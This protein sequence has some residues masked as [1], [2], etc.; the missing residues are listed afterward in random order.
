MNRWIQ[1]FRYELRQQFR[2]KAY[3]FITFGLPLIALAAFYGYQAYQDATESKGDEKPVDAVSA[4]QESVQ[5]S[6]SNPVGYVDQTPEKLFP[7]P[8]SYQPVN[9]FV[10]DD[11]AGRIQQ[12][13][14][15]AVQS[16]LI[17]RISSPYCL[18]GLVYVYADRDAGKKAL[19]DGTISVLY[20]IRPDYAARGAVDAYMDGFN[21]EGAESQTII[22]DFMLRSLL[23]NVEAQDYEALYLRLRDPAFVAEHTISASGTAQQE[24][25]SQNFILVYG[26]GLSM[27]LGIFWGG[28]YLMQSVV[29]EKE[30]RIIEILLSSVPPLPLL[31]GKI[32]AMGVVALLQVGMIIGTF[33]V[34]ITQAGDLS[35]SLG[36]IEVNTPVLVLGFVYFVLGYLLFGSLMATIGA[37]SSTMRESQNFVVVVTLPA[38][39]PFF[40]LTIFAEEPNSPLAVICSI[41]PI[42]AS[43]SMIMRLSVTD[44]PAAQIALSLA[45]LVLSVAGAIWFAGRLFRVN[46]LLRGSTPKLRDIPKLFRG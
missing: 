33:V 28:G 1:V 46:T 45:A 30:S 11:E 38:A 39:I 25:E 7:A 41:F 6:D 18:G 43:L 8:D 17:K 35:Q 3:L 2:S 22:T 42:T 13:G 36:N 14:A 31:L 44:V 26:F 20:I 5:G 9:C 12:G 23:Y 10:S 24:N 15:A 34:I 21:I 37:V 27:M 4:T 16:E 19:K 40:F 29:Q 32:L